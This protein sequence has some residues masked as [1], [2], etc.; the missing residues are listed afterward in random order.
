M[1]SLQQEL[2]TTLLLLEMQKKD[3]YKSMEHCLL[4]ERELDSLHVLIEDKQSTI[5]NLQQ[6]LFQKQNQIDELTTTITKTTISNSAF[7]ELQ[8][9]NLL[10]LDKLKEKKKEVQQLEIEVKFLINN[11]ENKT[12]YD[13]NKLIKITELDIITTS[14]ISS[15][16]NKINTLTTALSNSKEQITRLQQEKDELINQFSYELHNK[17]EKLFRSR[18]TEYLT[19]LKYLFQLNDKTILENDKEILSDTISINQQNN[20]LLQKELEKVVHNNLRNETTFTNIITTNENS[21][22]LLRKNEK[23]L[24]KENEKL[25]FELEL[26]KNKFR[27]VFAKKQAQQSLTPFEKRMQQ[28]GLADDGRGS[29]DRICNLNNNS[30]SN[31]GNSSVINSN[32]NLNKTIQI[33]QSQGSKSQNDRYYMSKTVGP[34]VSISKRP[35]NIDV[36]HNDTS[37]TK[38]RW[39][40]PA[41]PVITSNLVTID[42]ENTLAES[43]DDHQRHT[44]EQPEFPQKVKGFEAEIVPVEAESSDDK[45]TVQYFGNKVVS[46]NEIESVNH[47]GDG[48]FSMNECSYLSRANESEGLMLLSNTYNSMIDDGLSHSVLIMRYLETKVQLS[49]LISKLQSNYN[50]K[51]DNS[52]VINLDSCAVT[53]LDLD[54]V[55]CFFCCHLITQ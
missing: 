41:H 23:L 7:E 16:E 47:I 31:Y 26:Q 51:P 4:L 19:L 50:V 39:E 29:V 53:D 42:S 30:L 11:S 52:I 37:M 48:A 21:N 36:D 24:L 6:E 10:L 33:Q 46:N 18:Q 5:N 2:E 43:D 38:E 25:K 13:E 35:A 8:Q 49:T 27:A 15:Y 3:T 28:L 55:H 45:E 14:K 20:F 34:G 17:N 32:Q 9:Q 12:L 22:Y 44:T 40:T 54:Q 1:A